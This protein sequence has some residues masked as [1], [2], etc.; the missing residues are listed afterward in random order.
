MPYPF[1]LFVCLGINSLFVL[2][3]EVIAEETC[4]KEEKECNEPCIITIRPI[5][6]GSDPAISCLLRPVIPNTCS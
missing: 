2:S 5:K 6:M 1:F 4:E 3:T